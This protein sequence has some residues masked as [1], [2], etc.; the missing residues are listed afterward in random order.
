MADEKAFNPSAE[1]SDNE[2]KEDQEVSV[3][4]TVPDSIKDGAVCEDGVGMKEVKT[5]S[6]VSTSENLVEEP[7]PDQLTELIDAKKDFDCDINEVRNQHELHRTVTNSDLEF[8]IVTNSL[9]LDSNDLTPE[10]SFNEIAQNIAR[11]SVEA[12]EFSAIFRESF[13]SLSDKRPVDEEKKLFLIPESREDSPETSLLDLDVSVTTDYVPRKTRSSC[14]TILDDSIQYTIQSDKINPNDSIARSQGVIE[15]SL[16]GET[17]ILTQEGVFYHKQCFNGGSISEKNDEGSTNESGD[18]SEA[19]N[20]MAKKCPTSS[21]ISTDNTGN[22]NTC[23]YRNDDIPKDTV[24][25]ISSYGIEQSKTLFEKDA[26]ECVTTLGSSGD[27]SDYANVLASREDSS[28]FSS[29]NTDSENVCVK[30][31]KETSKDTAISILTKS[32]EESKASTKNDSEKFTTSSISPSEYTSNEAVQVRKNDEMPKDSAINVPNNCSDDTKTPENEAIKGTTISSSS[33]N[34]ENVYD[35]KND[36]FFKDSLITAATD[37]MEQST[38]SAESN[39]RQH[40]TCS[41]FSPDITISE[42]VC[43]EDYKAK[44]TSRD[45]LINSKNDMGQSLISTALN[46]GNY[47]SDN[48]GDERS[49]FSKDGKTAKHNL[50]TIS[51]SNTVQPV[52]STKT[53]CIEESET[54]GIEIQAIVDQ[55]IDSIH[56]KNSIAT[57][58]K[59][60]SNVATNATTDSVKLF[61]KNDFIVGWG[62]VGFESIEE[63]RKLESRNSRAEMQF[64]SE[65]VLSQFSRLDIHGNED[66]TVNLLETQVP[67]FLSSG[68][69]P[70]ANKKNKKIESL[71]SGHDSLSTK[72]SYLSPFKKVSDIVQK[73]EVKESRQPSGEASWDSRP[74]VKSDELKKYNEQR[75]SESE[76]NESVLISHGEKTVRESRPTTRLNELAKNDQQS[77]SGSNKQRKPQRRSKSLPSSPAKGKRRSQSVVTTTCLDLAVATFGV[78]L[79][80]TSRVLPDLHAYDANDQSSKDKVLDKVISSVNKPEEQVLEAAEGIKKKTSKKKKKSDAGLGEKKKKKKKSTDSKEQ[81]SPSSSSSYEDSLQS[82]PSP[83]KNRQSPSRSV[84]SP[85]MHYQ[86]PVSPMKKNTPENTMANMT[87]DNDGNHKNKVQ[88]GLTNGLVERIDSSKLPAAPA[89]S[90]TTSLP[91]VKELNNT[92]ARAVSLPDNTFRASLDPWVEVR[93][94]GVDVKIL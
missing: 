42:N 39:P 84:N 79:K 67:S 69:T 24:I 32:A 38:A 57:E 73:F 13:E 89:S 56:Q 53:I 86:F 68:T 7:S 65:T 20:N 75:K 87:A 94:Y 41:S 72:D 48:V 16:T 46:P 58:D 83:Q 3:A 36:V 61:E 37:N 62:A 43:K 51:I 29:Y 21:F 34:N 85:N 74:Q 8:D 10:I 35:S 26:V 88:H 44:D 30:T 70:L 47:S 45:S 25:S 12:A 52:A 71:D 28:F 17:T 9:L 78:V 60:E 76:L 11:P 63:V 4:S 50:T 49:C 55:N 91:S 18:S 93:K 82:T 2:L 23:V 15:E 66:N 64:D 80:R 54:N 5:V 92:Y 27:K 1:S 40:S 31:T 22:A 33:V 90:D 19:A 14:G 81:S 77:E 59:T 6:L